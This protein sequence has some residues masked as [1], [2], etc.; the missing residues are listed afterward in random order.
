MERRLLR[1]LKPASLEK[2]ADCKKDTRD[3]IELGDLVVKAGLRHADKAFILGTL[4]EA[5][6]LPLHSPRRQK[7]TA[8]GRGELAAKENTGHEK[9]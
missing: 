7:M 5:A 6:A 3:K 4:I 8:T 9:E 2:S 1:L